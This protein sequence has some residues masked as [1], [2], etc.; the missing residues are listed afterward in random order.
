M[1]NVMS[2]NIPA[3]PA[4]GVYISQLIRYSKILEAD[5]MLMATQPVVHYEISILQISMDIFLFT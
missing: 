4:Y 3:V 2:G 5:A 1:Q